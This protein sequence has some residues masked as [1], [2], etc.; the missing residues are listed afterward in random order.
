MRLLAND[1]SWRDSRHPPHACSQHGGQ[2]RISS[3]LVDSGVRFKVE[4]DDSSKLSTSHGASID[5]RHMHRPFEGTR[6]NQTLT[7][8]VCLR[9]NVHV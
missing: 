2:N 3:L 4:D 8:I 1:L 6:N 7:N 9:H 5:N